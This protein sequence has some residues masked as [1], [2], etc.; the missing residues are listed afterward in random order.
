M[1]RLTHGEWELDPELGTEDR[2]YG[3]VG[4]IPALRLETPHD[5]CRRLSGHLDAART[6]PVVD[7]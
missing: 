2:C 4:S 6:P 5:F 7:K 3:Q 1:V